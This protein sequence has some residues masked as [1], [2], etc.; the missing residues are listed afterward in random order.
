MRVVLLAE[1]LGIG[2]LPNYVLTLGRALTQSGADVLIAHGNAPLPDHLE[3]AGLS[4]RH[5]RGLAASDDGAQAA[6]AVAALR[7]WSPD[8]VHVHLCSS[9]AVI[10]QLLHSG[11]P[12][13]R[14]FH[15]YTSLCLRRGRRRWAGDRC[16]RALG[17]GCAAWGCML[18]PPPPG[19]RLPRLAGLSEKIAE[20]DR[21]REFGASVVGSEYMAETLRRNG[22][23]RSRIHIVPH[24]SRFQAA[25]TAM[26]PPVKRAGLP[27]RD[28]P[29][30]LLFAGQAVT[31]KGLEVLIAAL[32]GIPS[33]WQLSVLAE[34]PRLQ[35]ARAL[36]QATGISER[37]RFLGWAPQAETREHYR[38]A[39][40]LV[41]PSIWDDP[42]PLVGIEA[43]SFG[44]PLVGFAV[45]GISDYLLDGETGVLVDKTTADD[46]RRGLQHAMADAERLQGWGRAGRA[47]VARLHTQAAHLSALR[48]VYAAVGAAGSDAS[49]GSI[50]AMAGDAGLDR[51]T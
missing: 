31:G 14:S 28:R 33:D 25:A 9:L 17:W 6:A 30:E 5:L 34:G 24:F 11:L 13:V 32:A 21:Y 12:L 38:L 3:V 47:L 41:I 51:P 19:G 29:F 49:V 45:G 18:S 36:A 37:I 22:F 7:A 27:G 39:D 48:A 23:P 43:M 8:L 26:A 15:D 42:V 35:P 46:L 16:Q 4:L 20:R 44:T 2:G 40:M 10:D 1:E 50:M